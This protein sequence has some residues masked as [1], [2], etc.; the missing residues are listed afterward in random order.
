MKKVTVIIG[1]N[2]D[3]E[4]TKAIQLLRKTELKTTIIDF[5]KYPKKEN[6]SDFFF[7]KCEHDTRLVVIDKVNNIGFLESI[8]WNIQEGI[9]VNKQS[10]KSF[11]IDAEVV[12]IC[13]GITK[14]EIEETGASLIRRIELIEIEVVPKINCNCIEEVRKKLIE[15]NNANYV[16]I[17]MSTISV[18]EE[19]KTLKENLTGQRIEIG[20]NHVRRDGGI[21]RKERKSFIA[22]I[23]CPFCGVKY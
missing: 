19:G 9:Y 3:Y 4:P 2:S 23:F 22:H 21:Q 17:D 11:K 7:S 8:I 15:R 1:A 5:S 13:E 18:T 16:R 12:I 6:I 10:V 14:N 20:Y